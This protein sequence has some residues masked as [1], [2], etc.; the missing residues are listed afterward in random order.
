MQQSNITVVKKQKSVQKY[1]LML[2][3]I[4]FTLSLEWS[5]SNFYYTLKVS[6]FNAIYL[7]IFC[8]MAQKLKNSVDYLQPKE[9]ISISVHMLTCSV[10]SGHMP[11]ACTCITNFLG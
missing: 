8:Q 10:L 5:A 6:S 11:A 7:F 1:F 4:I 9:Q 2:C 3:L